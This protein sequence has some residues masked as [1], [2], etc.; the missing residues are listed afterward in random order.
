[1]SKVHIIGEIARQGKFILG[2]VAPG[3]AYEVDT[4]LHHPHKA[5]VKPKQKPWLYENKII[6]LTT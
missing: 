3:G 5:N 4:K 1:M 2:H 6:F